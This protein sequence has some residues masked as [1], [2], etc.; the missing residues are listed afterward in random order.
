MSNSDSKSEAAQAKR[1]TEQRL[2]AE[3]REKRTQQLR[4]SRS[5]IDKLAKDVKTGRANLRLC[6]E[7]LHHSAGFYEEVDKL[8]K[9]RTAFPATPLV[10]QNAN[11]I[12]GDAKKLVKVKEDVHMDRIKEFVPA[13]DEPPYPDVLVTIRS[14]R[15]CLNRHR[16]RQTARVSALDRKLRA[17]ETVAGALEYFLNDEEASDEDKQTPSKEAVQPYTNGRINSDCFTQFSDDSSSYYFDF[18]RLDSITFQDYLSSVAADTDDDEDDL[19]DEPD[20][21]E[22]GEDGDEE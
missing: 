6:N 4:E 16:D 15:N 9:G 21:D 12:I 3:L 8:A 18:D 5:A 19:L 11:D 10:R 14:V 1:A 7:L 22:D 20:Q 13:G 17:A 2:K